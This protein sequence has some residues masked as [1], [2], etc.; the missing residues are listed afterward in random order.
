MVSVSVTLAEPDICKTC[1]H[2]LYLLCWIT[3]QFTA[4][5]VLTM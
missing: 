1:A 5:F 2:A 3:F 4:T